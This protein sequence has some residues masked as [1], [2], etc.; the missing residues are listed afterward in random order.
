[1][2]EIAAIISN[3]GFP[4]ACCIVMFFLYYK[5][6][7]LHKEEIVK[8]TEAVNNNTNVMNNL[9]LQLERKGV[10]DETR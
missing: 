6:Q 5:S 2:E 7:E 3:L 9:I 10:L 4:I 1:M 8:I